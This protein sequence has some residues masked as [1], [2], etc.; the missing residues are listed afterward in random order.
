MTP[1]G[2]GGGGVYDKQGDS[3]PSC[4]PIFVLFVVL[5]KDT[6]LGAIYGVYT[7]GVIVCHLHV[8]GY[9]SPSWQATL[10][11]SLYLVGHGSFSPEKLPARIRAC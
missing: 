5:G 3:I 1:V 6:S 4:C 8:T 7:V 10:F 11:L 9:L 2:G